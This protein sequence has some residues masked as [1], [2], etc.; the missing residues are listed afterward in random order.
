MNFKKARQSDSESIMI[1]N[2]VVQLLISNLP[3]VTAADFKHSGKTENGNA[4][5]VRQ[6]LITK[7][8][9]NKEA[10]KRV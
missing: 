6:W 7:K 8:K 9:D 1:Q 3:K 5:H 10:H 2:A 4:L